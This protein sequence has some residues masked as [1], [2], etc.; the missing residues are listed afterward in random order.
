MIKRVFA[1]LFLLMCL[2][3]VPMLS[4]NAQET[5]ELDF[6]HIF[7][8]SEDLR[9]AVIQE[10]IDDFEALNPNITINSFSTSA[11]GSYEEV[12]LNALDSADLGDAPNIIQVEEGL[13]QQ[14]IDSGYFVAISDLASDEQ[15]ASID[16]ILPSVLAYYQLGDMI[17]SVPWNISNPVLYY[18]RDIF[19][20][21][22]LDPDAT[23][24]TFDDVIAVCE[25]IMA[26]T[27]TETCINW[28]MTSWFAEQWVAMKNELILN[29]DNGRSARATEAFY[30]TETMVEILTWWDQ[31]DANSYYAYTGVPDDYTGE[32]ITFVT[33]RSAM[34]VSSTAGLTNFMNFARFDLGVT[35]LP[36]PDE[37][38]TN[39][40]TVGGGSL[41]VPIDQTD[42][43]MQAAVDFIFF[44]TQTEN[45]IRWHQGS[46]YMPTRTSSYNQLLENGFY[47]EN[48]FFGVAVGQLFRSEV[49]VATAGGVMGPAN[50][51]RAQLIDAFRLIINGE[52]NSE[53][54]IRA[55]LDGA[56]QRAD[57]IFA[58]YN[59]DFE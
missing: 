31:L 10:I 59:R 22:G 7:G 38:A 46:G 36:I 40:V 3:F 47:D 16:D 5:I 30:N 1:P 28:P 15:L 50:D 24:T 37:D 53:E 27:D 21:A 4:I 52:A 55:A 34:S 42:A 23:P 29:N 48:P 2:S 58:D 39:G 57:D 54:E 41:F 8:D 18:N 12:F 9:G 45:D 11:E 13:T 56:K 49:N 35:E 43:E 6:V 44:L 33:G 14:A 17:W 51:V 25:T 19:V 26:N 32:F 20:E